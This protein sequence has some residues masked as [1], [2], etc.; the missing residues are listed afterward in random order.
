MSGTRDG[1]AQM[2]D[3]RDEHRR[4]DQVRRAEVMGVPVLPVR[5]HATIAGLDGEV[6][7]C[8]SVGPAGEVIAVWTAARDQ[9]VVNARSLTAAGVS[10]A[11]PGTARPVAARIT[12]HAPKLEAVIGIQDLTLAHIMVQPMPGGRFVVAGARCQWRPG[13]PDRNALLYDADGQ[14]TSAHVLGGGIGVLQATSSGQLWAAVGR[15]LRRGNLRQLRLGAG[16]K[17]T[18]RSAPTGSS[19]SL[20][21]WNP[22]GTSPV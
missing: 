6:R 17:A 15:V 10:F 12:V 2:S 20:P 14:V 8:S 1:M 3:W 4:R 5:E 21:P 13:A 9:D 16:R 18:S 22:N 19:G 7:V 11:E